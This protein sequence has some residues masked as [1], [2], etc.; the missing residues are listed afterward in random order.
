MPKEH[1]I[2]QAK[3]DPSENRRTYGIHRLNQGK[4][5]ND[6]ERESK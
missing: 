3:V 6:S 5:E 4:S 2:E 1:N